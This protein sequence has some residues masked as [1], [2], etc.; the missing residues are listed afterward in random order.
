[1][2]KGAT[3]VNEAEQFHEFMEEYARLEREHH[4]SISNMGLGV[5]Q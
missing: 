2:P 1:M 5:V 3:S 4:S